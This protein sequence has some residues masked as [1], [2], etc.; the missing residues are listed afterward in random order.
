E[1]LSTWDSAIEL[2]T[3]QI[4]AKQRRKKALMDQL[5][6]GKK[7]VKGFS[8]KWKITKFKDCLIPTSYPIDKPLI[9]YYSLGLRS[10]G[11]GTFYRYVEDPST[12]AMET[13]YEVK[14][15]ELIINITFAW[16]GAVAILGEN[17]EGKI[18]SHRFPTF[19]FNS[20]IMICEYFKQIIITKK[21]KYF[22]G[23]ISPGGAGRNRVLDQKDFLELVWNIPS[24]EEQRAIAA[25]LTAADDE[26]NILKRQ[27]EALRQ[28]KKGLMQK[29]LTGEVRVKI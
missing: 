6:S 22:M 20:D 14:R 7:R 29:L 16:E 24:V 12:V 25:I 9:S 4:E 13:L 18:V 23:L 27:C 17:D 1:I 11:K 19:K 28:Q 2:L 5:L 26:I 10:H 3:K 21:F 8:T 15:N